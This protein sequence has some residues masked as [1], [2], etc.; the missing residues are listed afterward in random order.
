MWQMKRTRGP[1]GQTHVHAGGWSLYLSVKAT[2]GE[3]I[4]GNRGGA[5][6]TKTVRENDG[7]DATQTRWWEFFGARTS[8][9]R[10]Q[11]ES[12]RYGQ[13]LRGKLERKEHVPVHHARNLDEFGFTARCS[14]A[15]RSS[16]ERHD[17]DTPKNV[18]REWKQRW[19]AYRCQATKLQTR[20]PANHSKPT[21]PSKPN[22]PKNS[23]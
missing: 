2:T 19:R 8:T 21:H 5:W 16:G 10:N 17:K 6:L 3:T 23:P 4:V 7:N 12:C 18:E 14:D 20:H 11:G 9:A 15:C 13:R 22:L 1:L